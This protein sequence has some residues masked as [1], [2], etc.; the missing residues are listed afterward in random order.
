MTLDRLLSGRNESAHGA[1]ATFID[2]D[3][4]IDI[5]TVLVIVAVTVMSTCEERGLVLF[6]LWLVPWR[7]FSIVGSQLL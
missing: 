6:E 3:I 5:G 4:D 2:I 7:I 1:L